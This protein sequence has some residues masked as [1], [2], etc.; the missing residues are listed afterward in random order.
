MTRST[1]QDLLDSR[2]PSA[3]N[4]DPTDDRCRLYANAACQLLIPKL[5]S[6]GTVV[7]YTVALSDP[8]I[9]NQT[10]TLPP[11][12]ATL[13]GIAICRRPKTIRPIWF[14][15]N[16]QGPGIRRGTDT[17]WCGGEQAQH[18]GNFC[19]FKDV[20]SG[21]GYKIRLQCD[22]A[23]DVGTQVLVLGQDDAG[24]T[25]R[26][27][28]SGVWSDGELVTL[29]QSPGTLSLSNFSGVLDLQ[30]PSGRSGQMW[31]Y[32][33]NGAANTLLGQYQAWEVRPSYR[34][35]L[36]PIL[37]NQTQSV[38]FVDIV[39]KM[40]FIPVR[41]ATDYL[42]IGNI[43]AIILAGLSVKASEEHLFSEAAIYLNGGMTKQGI[44]FQ[45]AVQILQEEMDHFNGSAEVP[46]IQVIQT[47]DGSCA[48][49]QLL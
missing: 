2:F 42:S 44:P 6:S 7:N 29:A 26:T 21:G 12:F 27:P 45:G 19:S 20:P 24:N 46:S 10:L 41:V 28:K 40:N 3:L 49:D 34:R 17:N 11:Q 18:I 4:I 9:T 16:S 8:H 32:A 36:I 39:G 48:V 22:V 35:Y 14:L 43:Q 13:E 33:W 15:Y 31:M 25:I 23:N 47:P 37:P 5:H 30:I 1:F 38:P